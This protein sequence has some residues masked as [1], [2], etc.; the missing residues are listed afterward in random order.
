MFWAHA[1]NLE[2]NIDHRCTRVVKPRGRVKQ[3]LSIFLEGESLGLR[4]REGY[5][6]LGFVSFKKKYFP[7]RVS[8]FIPS[9]TWYATK[10]FSIVLNFRW[11][12]LGDTGIKS[13]GTS[14]W[15]GFLKY[16]VWGLWCCRKFQWGLPLMSF[17]AFLFTIFLKIILRGP[18]FYHLFTPP[19]YL[20]M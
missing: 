6:I 18:V 14:S 4:K 5:P 15:K 20:L 8:V 9:F 17:I 10:L 3:V 16:L 11:I 12:F 13:R 7:G 1:S 2:V 19:P